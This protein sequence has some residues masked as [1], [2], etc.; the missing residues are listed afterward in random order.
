ML[1]PCIFFRTCLSSF[2]AV[3]TS[4]KP[5]ELIFLFPHFFHI[6]SDFN[7]RRNH[8]FFNVFD[9][10]YWKNKRPFNRILRGNFCP[11]YHIGKHRKEKKE[12]LI[13][14]KIHVEG[15][16]IHLFLSI[17]HRQ[18]QV[19]QGLFLLQTFIWLVLEL[20]IVISS[21]MNSS[22]GICWLLL[23]CCHLLRRLRLILLELSLVKYT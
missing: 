17:V 22:L 21:L 16:I 13:E 23:S 1:I 8:S 14:K 5:L 4:K 20:L 10:I 12:D 19:H 9:R 2:Y 3:H 15:Q 11:L 18:V 6:N 7:H